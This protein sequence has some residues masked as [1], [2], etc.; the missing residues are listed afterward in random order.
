MSSYT[1]ISSDKLIRLIGTASAPL[2]VD[3]GIDDDF[4]AAPRAI[5]T[6]RR[7][8]ADVLIE[9]VRHHPKSDVLKPCYTT[10]E[11]RMGHVDSKHFLDGVL[12]GP[13]FCRPRPRADT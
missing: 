13:A 7:S 12:S 9:Q 4:A 10:E 5:P 11:R 8:H 2:L 1:S 6:Q 3:V